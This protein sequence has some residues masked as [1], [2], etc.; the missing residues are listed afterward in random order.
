MCDPI[1]YPAFDHIGADPVHLHERTGVRQNAGLP[2]RR[3]AK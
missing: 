3:G 2:A 1:A